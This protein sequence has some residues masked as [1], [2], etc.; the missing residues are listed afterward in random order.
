MPAEAPG[1][2]G[3]F[4]GYRIVQAYMQKHPEVTLEKLLN[5]R[6]VMGIFNE[7]RYRP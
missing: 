4:T 7:A 2:I 1:Q 5:M 3:A 6:D